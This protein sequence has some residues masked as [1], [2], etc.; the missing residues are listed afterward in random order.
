MRCAARCYLAEFFSCWIQVGIL[1]IGVRCDIATARAPQLG[2]IW[3]RGLLD[4]SYLSA[5]YW[6]LVRRACRSVVLL[7]AYANS[8]HWRLVRQC[9][10]A[11]RSEVLLGTV[12]S[13]LISFLAGFKSAC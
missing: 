5:S 11:V 4:R 9:C 10:G 13:L 7:G 12:V 1:P 3:Q 2:A 6:R 8:G